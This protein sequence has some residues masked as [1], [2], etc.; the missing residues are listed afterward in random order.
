MVEALDWLAF[1]RLTDVFERMH[2]SPTEGH[3]IRKRFET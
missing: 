3:P 1:S 2:V